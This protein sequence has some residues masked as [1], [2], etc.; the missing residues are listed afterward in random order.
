MIGEVRNDPVLEE[1]AIRSLDDSDPEVVG[2]AARGL[3]KFG[4]A[5]AKNALWQR[6]QRWSAK[7]AGRESDL[8]LISADVMSEKGE[9]RLIEL[10]LGQNLMHAIA[11]GQLW[12][13]DRA[14]LQ[15]LSEITKVRRLQQELDTYLKNWGDEPLTLVVDQGSLTHF[16]AQVAHY[17]FQSMDELKQKLRQFPSGTRF[18]LSASASQASNEQ[19]AEVR[20]FLTEH[21]M[22]VEEK[23]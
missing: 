9:G 10:G 1:I 23:R 13:S 16:H 8:D 7:W 19:R 3:K 14:E 2:A 20:D 17:E 4:S 22:F 18:F 6:Y 12:L 11:M 21:G 15:R 5:E